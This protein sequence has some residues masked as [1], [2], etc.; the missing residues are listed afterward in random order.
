MSEVLWPPSGKVEY[1]GFLSVP[2]LMWWCIAVL[3]AVVGILGGFPWGGLLVASL[4]ALWGRAQVGGVRV[5][6]RAQSWV[7]WRLI[8]RRS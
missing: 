2:D 8:V 1:L 6:T 4:V 7:R 3:C 5:R